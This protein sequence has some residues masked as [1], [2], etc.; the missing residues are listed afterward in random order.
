MADD[1]YKILGVDKNAS[2]DEIRKAY[3][4]LAKDLHPD[5][6]PGN[7]QAE[8][9]FKKV[10]AAYGLLGD[11]DKRA[12][13]DK[14][15]IDETG[16]E[17]PEQQFYRDFAD[18]GGARHYYSSGGFE[19]LGAAG[20]I[21]EDLFGGGHRGGERSF[22]I[23]GGDAYYQL[24]VDFLD[25]V[26]GGK[27]RITLPDGSS[28]DL[29]IP[30]GVEQ[31]QVLRLKGK[32]MPGYGGGPPGDAL[33]EVSVGEHPLFKRDGNDIRVEVPI[34]VDE[35][36]LGGKIEVPTVSG[37]VTMS[38][39]K[40]SSSGRSLRLRGKGVKRGKSAGDQ[41]VTLKIVLPD[42]V[43]DEL[44]AFLKTWR[45]SHRYDPRAKLKGAGR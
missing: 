6:N 42:E 21:F 25:A 20:G 15:E 36:V 11:P 12:R 33:V 32:G 27:K 35:A 39:P 29:S 19:D 34:T 22:R 40:G 8:E 3:R 17:R 2:Q 30:A 37:R 23:R 5:L 24:H 38:V 13:Y 10:S 18:S 16:A 31:G 44:A 45:D 1:P 4:K 28:L 43:D 7:A 14:G 41:L 26:K 9:Q